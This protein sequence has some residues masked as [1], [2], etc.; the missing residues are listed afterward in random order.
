MGSVE[1]TKEVKYFFHALS[2]S[3]DDDKNTKS[4]RGDEKNDHRD[5][6]IEENFRHRLLL[7]AQVSFG[8]P[9]PMQP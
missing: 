6:D 8:K 5:N 2:I 7:Y 3:T 9:I 4:R 1:Q